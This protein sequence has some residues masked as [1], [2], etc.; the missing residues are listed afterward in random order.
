LPLGTPRGRVNDHPTQSRLYLKTDFDY[1]IVGIDPSLVQKYHLE[2]NLSS[3]LTWEFYAIPTDKLI[4]H[5]RMP[6]RL[7][8]LQK[9]RYLDFQ[10]YLIGK[11]WLDSWRKF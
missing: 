2:V 11:D 3:E 1:L 9:L 6:H 8:S 4:G 7:N 5:P 10:N